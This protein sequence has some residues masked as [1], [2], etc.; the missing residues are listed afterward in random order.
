M[1]IVLRLLERDPGKERIEGGLRR[2]RARLLRS[3]AHEGLDR[4]PIR[5]QRDVVRI[6]SAVDLL[7]WPK[8]PADP[9]GLEE[10]ERRRIPRVIV[11]TALADPHRL[12]PFRA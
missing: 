8:R 7:P 9:I 10:G 1:L 3:V 4:A 5:G 6:V 12:V 2:R 11:L